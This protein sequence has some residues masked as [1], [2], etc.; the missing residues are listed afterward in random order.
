MKGVC[1]NV[2][3]MIHSAEMASKALLSTLTNIPKLGKEFQ[4]ITYI[5]IY[6]IY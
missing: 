3:E 4:S 6:T 5:H 2:L 1:I